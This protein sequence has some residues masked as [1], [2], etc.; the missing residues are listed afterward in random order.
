MSDSNKARKDISKIINKI[1]FFM[2]VLVIAYEV[3][4]LFQV[5]IE[6]TLKSTAG[7]SIKILRDLA[8][9]NNPYG[10]DWLFEDGSLPVTYWETGFFHIL[11]SLLLI[12]VFHI[13]PIAAAAIIHILYVTFAMFL[14]YKIVKKLSGG[15]NSALLASAV[16][17][18]C[19]NPTYVNGI[20][21]DTLCVLLILLIISIVSNDGIKEGIKEW[22]Y[23]FACVLLLFL[24]I[25]YASIIVPVYIICFKKKR[26]IQLSI[27]N[28]IIGI[29]FC[30]ITVICF[31]TFFSTFGVRVIQMFTSNNENDDYYNMLYQWKELFI[32][33]VPLFIIFIIGI[34]FSIKKIKRIIDSD[35]YLFLAVDV[36]VNALGLCYMGK[37]NGNFLAYHNVMFV[38]LLIICSTLVLEK[39]MRSKK[40]EYALVSFCIVVSSILLLCIFNKSYQIH[41]MHFQISEHTYNKWIEENR[42]GEMLLSSSCTQFAY[43]NDYYLWDWGDQ[44]YLPY[45]IGT[46]PRWNALFPY[47]NQYRNKNIEYANKV[48]EKINNREYSLIVS[49][50]YNE[51]GHKIGMKEVFWDAIEENYDLMEKD[52]LVG[53]WIPKGGE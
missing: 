1:I 49:N 13:S 48:L 42:D 19:L 3:V 6:K 16:L 22:I 31:P 33:Y 38:P 53:Y 8:V 7:I 4:Y 27:K 10:K 11:P 5:G 46:S 14:M 29:I 40:K 21:P 45:D 37:W 43:D 15:I 28:V 44:I 30:I 12:R 9:G 17:Y 47:T 26:W 35:I 51:F 18:V 24:K 32:R 39:I 52:D 25:H 50:D 34:P 36:I 20:R 2:L 41:K 23:A